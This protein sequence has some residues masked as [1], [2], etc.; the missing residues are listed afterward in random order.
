MTFGNRK[1]SKITSVVYTPG[2]NPVVYLNDR[3]MSYYFKSTLGSPVLEKLLNLNKGHLSIYCVGGGIG[4]QIQLV[5][6]V[7]FSNLTNEEML[8]IKQEFPLVDRT[9]GRKRYPKSYGG[10][11]SRAR[12]QKSYR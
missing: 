7:I 9:D 11:K 10:R 8:N 2:I 3:P 6:K 1:K 5:E 12:S 4:S